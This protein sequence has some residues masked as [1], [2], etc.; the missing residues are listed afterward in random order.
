VIIGKDKQ[1]RLQLDDAE[2]LAVDA[3]EVRRDVEHSTLTNVGRDGAPVT[4]PPGARV[5]LWAGPSVV[6]VGK[7]VDE[8]RVLDLISSAGDDELAD[9]GSI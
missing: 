4:F 6:F 2:P 8:H 7:A 9:H 3:A 1:P 5:T